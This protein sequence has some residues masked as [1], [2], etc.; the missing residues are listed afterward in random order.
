MRTKKQRKPGNSKAI[1]QRAG[2]L[3]DLADYEEWRETLLPALRKDL[4]AGLTAEEIQEKY[5]AILAARG[6][7]LG[8]TAENEA[9]ALSAIK[10][11]LDR[12]DG[13]AVERRETIHHLSKLPEKE[14]D[15]LLLSQLDELD[16]DEPAE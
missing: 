7:Q 13:K 16:S 1:T 5:K 15:A 4:K 3:D 11:V 2:Q 9:V 12:R 10:D 14:I 6:V 8:A